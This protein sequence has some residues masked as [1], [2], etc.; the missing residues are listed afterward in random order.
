MYRDSSAR[1]G[2]IWTA[3]PKIS[4]WIPPAYLNSNL[5]KCLL[6]ICFVAALHGCAPKA[7]ITGAPP[8][9]SPGFPTPIRTSG[10]VEHEGQSHSENANE[11]LAPGKQVRPGDRRESGVSDSGSKP[12]VVPQEA[13][14]IHKAPNPAKAQ[15][16]KQASTSPVSTR[17]TAISAKVKARNCPVNSIQESDGIIRS[18]RFP[19]HSLTI[20]PETRLSISCNNRDDS[21]TVWLRAGILRVRHNNGVPE[22]YR[23]FVRT[24]D[25]T[26]RELGT[27]YYV[28]FLSE[29]SALLCLDGNISLYNPT[30]PTAALQ[31]E[32][33]AYVRRGE[34][35]HTISIRAELGKVQIRVTP[36]ASAAKTTFK[37]YVDNPVEIDTEVETDFEK[38][39]MADYPGIPPQMI[40]AI[41]NL[42]NIQVQVKTVVTASKPS[43]VTELKSGLADKYIDL[44]SDKPRRSSWDVTPHSLSA[45][46]NLSIVVTPR[47]SASV[48]GTDFSWREIPST[49]VCQEGHVTWSYWGLLMFIVAV[50]NQVSVETLGIIGG[51]L[52]SILA[53]IFRNHPRVM[54]FLTALQSRL[55]SEGESEEGESGDKSNEERHKHHAR[56]RGAAK[57]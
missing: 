55:K 56:K 10:P 46:C 36:S 16:P 19:G 52:L 8:A 18:S 41:R 7:K 35:T 24:S 28:L 45:P 39:L 53:Y 1:K 51:V 6:T 32:Q 42:M 3:P 48:G 25:L 20:T 57:V 40:D 33:M 22:R 34:V 15:P 13:T 14:L 37:W 9:S 43:C 50:G 31:Q 47:V 54:K 26:I 38:V 44:P 30:N 2:A 49:T 5:T 29:T 27:D 11:G 21:T 12:S 4:A 17:A 23:L